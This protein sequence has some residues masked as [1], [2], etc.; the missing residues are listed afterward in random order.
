MHGVWSRFAISFGIMMLMSP[1]ALRGQKDEISN[2]LKNIPKDVGEATQPTPP[3]TSAGTGVPQRRTIE[4][5]GTYI[6]QSSGVQ[7][8]KRVGEFGR[9]SVELYDEEGRNVGGAYQKKIGGSIVNVMSVF[10]YPVAGRLA[11]SGTAAIFE[12]E[13]AAITSHQPNARLIREE[14]YRAANGVPGDFAEYEINIS[15][16]KGKTVPVRSRIYLF[17]DRGW[18]L[19]FRTTY[20]VARAREGA[21]ETEAFLRGF[22][23]GVVRN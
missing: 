23:T 7:F 20:P 9:T 6:N 8:P 14:P 16:G 11:G 3:Q 15:V 19:K 17:A 18:L 21:A 4:P 10:S 22:G 5:A 12:A 13:K 2:D 1:A